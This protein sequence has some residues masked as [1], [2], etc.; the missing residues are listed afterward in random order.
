MFTAASKNHVEPR[1]LA[2]VYQRLI[3]EA[4]LPR[5]R[6]HDLRHT[7]ASLLIRHGVAPKIVADRL[8]HADVRFTLQVYTHVYDDQRE[9]AALPMDKLLHSKKTAKPGIFAPELA[10]GSLDA[11]RDLHAALGKFLAGQSDSEELRRTLGL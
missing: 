7:A 4:Q 1:H 2:K 6:F 11:L 8:G 9:E 5:I 3:D 10:V